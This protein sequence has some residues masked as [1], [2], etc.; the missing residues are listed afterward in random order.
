MPAYLT[1]PVLLGSKI[2]HDDEI[3]V[4]RAANGALRGFART[5]GKKAKFDV[6]HI[7]TASERT[8]ALAY[9]DTNRLEDIVLTWHDGTAYTARFVAAPDEEP[10]GGGWF[11]LRMHMEEA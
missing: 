9:Y 11:K 2:R 3:T 5:V 7:C 10:L 6:E 4:T 1:L 8:T